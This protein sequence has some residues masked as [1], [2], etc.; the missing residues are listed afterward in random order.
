MA[1]ARV[2]IIITQSRRASSLEQSPRKS[3]CPQSCAQQ[4]YIDSLLRAGHCPGPQDTV[5]TETKEVF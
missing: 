4:M 3:Q 5:M 1:E 2:F